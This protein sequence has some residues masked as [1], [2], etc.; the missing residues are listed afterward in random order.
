MNLGGSG[1]GF[2]GLVT[3]PPY[4]YENCPNIG[5][6]NHSPWLAVLGWQTPHQEAPWGAGDG[7]PVYSLWYNAFNLPQQ[8]TP[9]QWTAV[10]KLY[11]DDVCRNCSKDN[12]WYTGITLERNDPEVFKKLGTGWAADIVAYPLF[13]R[14]K[15]DGGDYTDQEVTFP[16]LC[17]STQADYAVRARLMD[18]DFRQGLVEKIENE[19]GRYWGFEVEDVFFLDDPELVK[20]LATF[21]WSGQT[22][23]ACYRQTSNEAVFRK[24][25]YGGNKF[26]EFWGVRAQA[27]RPDLL[28]YVNREGEHKSY[29]LSMLPCERPGGGGQY[30]PKRFEPT[31]VGAAYARIGG[32]DYF[33][34]RYCPV[35][36]TEYLSSGDPVSACLSSMFADL[37]SG[38][39]SSSVQTRLIAVNRPGSEGWQYYDTCPDFSKGEAE[40]DSSVSSLVLSSL[41]QLS[42]GEWSLFE[43]ENLSNQIEMP[44]LTSQTLRDEFVVREW[45]DGAVKPAVV[46][47]MPVSSMVSAVSSLIS[48]SFPDADL[49]SAGLSSI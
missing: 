3:K 20:T 36:W 21:D 33:I 48:A 4:F 37:L 2:R 40:P 8:D 19:I 6:F 49:S 14:V 31:A 23:D 30:V 10:Q 13:A 38:S 43:F 46:R 18:E 15:F 45:Y 34:P 26:K 44:S 5:S 1:Q 41:Q 9:E 16:V 35:P 27:Y 22:L 7:E 28:N 29:D 11:E 42:G 47:Y 39:L 32:E 24:R 25:E 12:W 17:I